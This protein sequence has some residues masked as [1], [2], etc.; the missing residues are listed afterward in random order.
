M[1]IG[2]P[3]HTYAVRVSL[4]LDEQT[5]AEAEALAWK[6]GLGRSE[7]WRAALREYLELH[8]GEDVMAALNRVH[9]KNTG[10]DEDLRR[11]AARRTFEANEW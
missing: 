5:F 7:L 8:R 1:V 6:L 2:E 10:T 3:L 11:E 4:S 9:G